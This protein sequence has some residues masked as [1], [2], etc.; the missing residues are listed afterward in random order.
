MYW[1][2]N[3]II[4]DLHPTPPVTVTE[5]I[6]GAGKK[7]CWWGCGISKVVLKFGLNL[8]AGVCRS[9]CDADNGFRHLNGRST[10]KSTLAFDVVVGLLKKKRDAD[11]NRR[12]TLRMKQV[13]GRALIC[14]LFLN[15]YGCSEIWN[16]TLRAFPLFF[17]T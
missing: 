15:S 10:A 5:I 7:Q 11:I 17:L 1:L 8:F 16:T 13:S 2:G 12:G 4:I 3:N 9:R 14:I 6:V